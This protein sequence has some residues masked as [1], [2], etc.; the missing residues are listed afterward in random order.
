MSLRAELNALRAAAEE[1]E[2]A[3]ESLRSDNT[4]LTHRISYLEE[5]VAEM[6]ARHAQVRAIRI[7]IQTTDLIKN[8]VDIISAF[9]LE[10]KFLLAA[11][12]NK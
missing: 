5:Q 6:L 7:I 8:M 10:N 4:R 2:R 12:T 1:T 11:P 3:K 9:Q